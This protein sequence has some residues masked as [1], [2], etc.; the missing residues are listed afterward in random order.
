MMGQ[1]D[2]LFLLQ[3]YN[4]QIS[5]ERKTGKSLLAMLSK[6]FGPA[7]GFLHGKPAPSGERD[8]R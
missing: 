6:E 1:F 5:V 4:K 3:T 2:K 8:I 7:K